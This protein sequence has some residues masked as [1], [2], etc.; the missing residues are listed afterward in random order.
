MPGKRKSQHL[1]LKRL[2]WSLQAIGS[3]GFLDYLRRK[4]IGGP[5]SDALWVK[6]DDPKREDQ[7]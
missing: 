1:G 6:N 4:W 2:S 5:V 3:A 7:P